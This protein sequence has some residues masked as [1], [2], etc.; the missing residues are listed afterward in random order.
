MQ[1]IHNG[2]A[3]LMTG[4]GLRATG[5]NAA[6]GTTVIDSSTIAANP[7]GIVLS[8][9]GANT[10]TVFTVNSQIVY[11][12]TSAN[13]GTGTT[14]VLE[15]TSIVSLRNGMTNSCQIVSYGDNAIRVTITGN[16]LTAAS[17]GL[18]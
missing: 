6:F 9:T 2:L 17:L 7:I 12:Q 11:N 18:R 16:G 10:V 14:L 5:G 1:L 8:Q 3:N 15:K 4:A 13:I